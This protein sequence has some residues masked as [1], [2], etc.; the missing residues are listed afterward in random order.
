[1]KADT[2]E[3]EIDMITRKYTKLDKKYKE[4]KLKIDKISI[5]KLE[6]E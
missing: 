5:E 4:S 6:I 2:F 1:V 3:G